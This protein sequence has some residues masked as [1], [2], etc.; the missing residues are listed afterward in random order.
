MEVEEQLRHILKTKKKWNLLT[1]IECAMEMHRAARRSDG[2]AAI[3]VETYSQERRF[4]SPNG[5]QLEPHCS[6]IARN[7]PLAARGPVCSSIGVILVRPEGGKP[8]KDL[9]NPTAVRR[10]HTLAALP[11]TL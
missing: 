11:Q 7:R 2:W 6:G 9:K 8:N 1:L 4:G 3:G 5:F 10:V